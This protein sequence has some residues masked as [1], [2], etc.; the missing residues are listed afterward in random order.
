[1]IG[2]LQATSVIGALPPVHRFLERIAGHRRLA[3][4]LALLVIA[5][6][7]AATL[8][9]SH[10]RAN[11]AYQTQTVLQ[12][13]LTQSVTAS[14]TVNPQNTVTVGTQV[15]GTIS[16]IYVDFNSKVRKGQVLARIDTS[17]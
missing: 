6:L 2:K 10:S 15:S 1:M 17:Q 4:L 3:A 11:P 5:G 8:T 12:Q 9:I 16:A 7:L 13:D 14:G